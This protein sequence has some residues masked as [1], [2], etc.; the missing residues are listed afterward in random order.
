MFVCNSLC[1]LVN[2]FAST[3]AKILK[4]ALIDFY[5]GDSLSM[6]KQQLLKDFDSVHKHVGITTCAITSRWRQQN[7]PRSGRLVHDVKCVR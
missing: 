2:K 1:F 5:N 6:A 3:N 4:T 7:T